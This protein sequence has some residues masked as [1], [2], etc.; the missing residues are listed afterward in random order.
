M[1]QRI[2]HQLAFLFFVK[3]SVD[4]TIPIEIRRLIT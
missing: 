4:H 1:A 3:F 2:A